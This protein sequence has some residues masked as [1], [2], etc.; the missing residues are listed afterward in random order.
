MVNVTTHGRNCGVYGF[1]KDSYGSS[2][3]CRGTGSLRSDTG[4]RDVNSLPVPTA[5]A[6]N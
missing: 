6:I 2:S 1:D 4:C 3:T 5:L